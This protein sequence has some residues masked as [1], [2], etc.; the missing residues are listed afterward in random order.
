MAYD[1]IVEGLSMVVPRVAVVLYTADEIEP[2]IC[3]KQSLD[4]GTL[5]KIELI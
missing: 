1:A 2:L 4:I 3:G 5:I